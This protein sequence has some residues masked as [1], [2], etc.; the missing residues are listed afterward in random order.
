MS[1]NHKKRVTLLDVARHANVSKAVAS[2]VINNGPRGT[3]PEAR[4][5]VLKAIEELGY[6]PN[7]FARSLST[8]RSH[9]IGF[10][11]YDVVPHDLFVS[12]YGSHILSGLLAELKEHEHYL[13]IYWQTVSESLAPLDRLL[14]SGRLD[15]VVIRLT[16]NPPATD[17][18]METI[19]ASN[20]P[21]VCIERPCA[22]RFGCKLVTYDDALGA[23]MATRYL[24]EQGHR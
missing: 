21:C 24:I 6:Y 20:I 14:R 23:S 11:D 4:E 18:L 13:L 12:P 10:I 3:S 17:A 7:A 9:I 19:M 15:G 2:Y 16:Q 5:R 8:Q 1:N 22:Y